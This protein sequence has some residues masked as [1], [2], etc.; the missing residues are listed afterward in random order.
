MSAFAL[1]KRVSAFG[2]SMLERGHALDAQSHIVTE[3]ANGVCA[4][5]WMRTDNSPLMIPA[6]PRVDDYV[7]VLR[8]RNYSFLM[9]DASIVRLLYTLKGAKII[10][11][12]VTYWPSPFVFDDY[13]LSAEEPLVDVIESFYLDKAREETVLVGQ[14]RFDYDPSSAA[15][16]HAASHLTLNRPECRIP[17]RSPLSFDTFMRFVLENFYQA[18]WADKPIRDQ[19]KFKQETSCLHKDD[20]RKIHMNWQHY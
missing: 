18:A 14:L 8:N 10:K 2:F 16:N 4:L 20:T 19:L 1:G 3:Y 11:H 7:D 17:V 12:C 13:A 6:F 5:S 9:S 15:S